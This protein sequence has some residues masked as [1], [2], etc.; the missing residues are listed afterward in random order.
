[1]WRVG[2]NL[3]LSCPSA[4]SGALPVYA[5]ARGAGEERLT[6]WLVKHGKWLFLRQ[7]EVKR[8]S[9]RFASHGSVAV[10]FSQLLPGVRGLAALVRGAGIRGTSAARSLWRGTSLPRSTRLDPARRAH[11]R[12]GA[13]GDQ[14]SAS[15]SLLSQLSDSFASPRPYL[16]GRSLLTM[17]Q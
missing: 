3:S 10:F 16:A 15:M 7:S 4:P 1:M 17:R 9:N 13:L 2:G 6:A 8:A 12:Y 14:T 5:V 11:A